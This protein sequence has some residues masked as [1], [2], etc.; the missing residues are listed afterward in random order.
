[1]GEVLTL[2]RSQHLIL[3]GDDALGEES[4]GIGLSIALVVAVDLGEER[5]YTLRADALTQDVEHRGQD[6]LVE[7]GDV[8]LVHV[9]DTGLDLST[10]LGHVLVADILE[11]VGKGCNLHTAIGLGEVGI[12]THQ[13]CLPLVGLLHL[14]EQPLIDLGGLAALGDPLVE[15]LLL[16][17]LSTE[18]I[19]LD[20]GLVHPDGVLPVVGAAGVLGGILDARSLIS[21]H[22][23]PPEL[24]LS[25]THLDTG[26]VLVRHTVLNGEGGDIATRRAG[27]A[28]GHRI[29]TLLVAFGRDRSVVLRLVGDI[30]LAVVSG[31]IVLASVDAEDGEVPRLARPHPVVRITTELT[32][33]SRRSEDETDVGEDVVGQ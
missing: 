16:S 30:V 5:R 25:A 6:T 8:V 27:E 15:G 9:L 20:E 12:V 7:A 2:D 32:Y 1:M 23:C 19:E 13:R 24:L 26:S 18:D 29:V 4:L 3:V 21:L 11:S 33:R 28:Y 22:R 17:T 31:R 10:I 14:R